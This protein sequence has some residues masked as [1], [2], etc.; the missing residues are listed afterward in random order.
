MSR[1]LSLMRVANSRGDKHANTWA[2]MKLGSSLK[3][4]AGAP[5]KV[6]VILDKIDA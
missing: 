6:G 1:M 5:L 2:F 4:D 3:S